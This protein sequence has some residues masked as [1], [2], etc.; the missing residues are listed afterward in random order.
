LCSET[1]VLSTKSKELFLARKL[2]LIRIDARFDSSRSNRESEEYT[3]NHALS[4]REEQKKRKKENNPQ[5]PQKSID[6]KR[7]EGMTRS[8]K[9]Q[10]IKLVTMTTDGQGNGRV[11]TVEDPMYR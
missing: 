8:G 7:S 5:K 6:V 4:I 2:L 11:V 10:I 3:N 9:C 1:I